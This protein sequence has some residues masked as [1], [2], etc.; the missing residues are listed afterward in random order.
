[1]LFL[2]WNDNGPK[3]YPV[4]DAGHEEKYG[5]MFSTLSNIGELETCRLA[6]CREKKYLLSYQKCIY[7][8]GH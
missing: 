6:C 8:V 7:E 4:G 1:M 5:T 2:I 3:S